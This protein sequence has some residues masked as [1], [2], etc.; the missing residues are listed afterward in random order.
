MLFRHTKQNLNVEAAHE[1]S[2]NACTRLVMLYIVSQIEISLTLWL[3]FDAVV[4][5]TLNV[6]QRP[7]K[8][9]SWTLQ[10]AVH[11][12]AAFVRARSQIAVNQLDQAVEVFGRHR[13]VFL[14]K[15]VHVSIEDFDKKLDGDGGIHACVGDPEGALQ[16]FQHSFAFSIGLQKLHVSLFSLVIYKLSTL[17]SLAPS[18]RSS[19][20]TAHHR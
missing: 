16:T 20:S 12:L 11:V 18:G 4:F 3:G 9:L 6:G 1:R 14:I 5:S 7:L 2:T 15:I 19:L 13:V 10:T 8:V 17:T